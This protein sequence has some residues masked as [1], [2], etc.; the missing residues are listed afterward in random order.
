MSEVLQF[1]IKRIPLSTRRTL[2]IDSQY[3]ELEGPLANTRFIK[4]DIEAYRF[5]ST[6]FSFYF[7]AVNTT[8][9][10]EVKCSRKKIMLIR[11]HSFFGIGKKKI[12]SLF[13]QIH[14]QIQNAY[15]N[16]MAIHYVQLLNSGLTYELAGV[17]LSND[18][19]LLKK[20]KQIIPWIRIGVKSYFESCS[21][22]DITDQFHFRSFD[23]WHDWNASL[24]H[25]VIRYKTHNLQLST[26]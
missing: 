10:I 8:Y 20:E 18:G 24:L 19:V 16:D 4:E 14:S 13:S 9:N 21:I 11:M 6:G 25:A 23:Y 22:Y 12:Q 7:F 5:G 1:H 26:F 2:T 3:I 17:F 15:F